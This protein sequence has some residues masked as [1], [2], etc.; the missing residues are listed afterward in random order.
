MDP[1]TTFILPRTGDS[2]LRVAG[3]LVAR[4]SS[5]QPKTKKAAPLETRWH[6]LAVYL[7]LSG[8]H[9][10]HIHYRTTWPGEFDD[11]SAGAGT[12]AELVTWLKS[13]DPCGAV[14]GFPPGS[15][16]APRQARLLDAI[17]LGYD[18]A[19]SVVLTQLGV[20]DVAE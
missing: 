1:V 8:K 11:S 20:S 7:T 12:L 3:V 9:V 16:F 10:A 14:I 19:L 6:E 17:E 5:Q 13:Y 18:S 2:P 4:A 15:G